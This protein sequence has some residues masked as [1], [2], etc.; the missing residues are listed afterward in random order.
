MIVVVVVII[1]IGHNR[2]SSLKNKVDDCGG[3]ASN[4]C[5]DGATLSS[6]EEIDSGVSE[7]RPACTTAFT[8]KKEMKI[9]ARL[10][11]DTIIEEFVFP[12]IIILVTSG[13]S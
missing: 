7:H 4:H 2:W 8:F 9:L 1:V 13:F 5:R 11:V 6:R 3:S 10:L 12:K